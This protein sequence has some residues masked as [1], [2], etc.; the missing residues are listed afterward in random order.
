[1]EERTGAMAKQLATLHPWHR[2]GVQIH[3]GNLVPANGTAGNAGT[4][5]CRKIFTSKMELLKW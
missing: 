4:K 5:M 1:M 3:T 2:R